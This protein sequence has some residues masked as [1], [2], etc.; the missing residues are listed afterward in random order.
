MHSLKGKRVLVAGGAGFI[1]S[2]LVDRLVDEEPAGLVVVDSFFLGCDENLVDARLRFESLRVY[3]LDARDLAAMRQL[4]QSERIDVVFNLA[5]VPLPTSLDYPAWTIRT[6]IDIAVTFCELARCC[7]I[8][9]LVHFSSSE[10]YGSAQYV[11]MDEKHPVIPTTPYAASKAACDQIVHSYRETFGIDTYIVR[12]FN[13]FGP[14]QNARLFAGVIPTVARRAAMGEPIEIFG[15]GEQTRDYV[16]VSDTAEAAVRLY[17][18]EASRG[19]IVNVATGCETSVNDL[20][21]R[22]LR[23]LGK[24]NHP[25]R[26]A[27]SRPADVRR[28]RGAPYLL[29]ELTGFEAAQLSDE[30]LQKTLDWHQRNGAI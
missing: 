19:R 7:D 29:K 5:V 30:R 8:Q 1:G 13:N 22:I 24:P 9:T 21:A 2:H 25:V 28:H 12:P 18:V 16:F 23:I 20:V 26:H 11:P 10:A 3:R 6:N 17:H 4:V 27:A 14:R 15:D